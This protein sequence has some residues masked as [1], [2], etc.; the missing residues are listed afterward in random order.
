MPRGKILTDLEKGQ[1]LAFKAENLSLR[2]IARRLDR[3]LRVVQNFLKSPTDYGK[4]K[5]PGR[6]N[7]LS[8][9]DVAHITRLA[10]NSSSSV[11]KIRAQSGVTA[12][13]ST[14]WRA[15][16]RNANIVRSKMA[17]VQKLLPRHITARLKF[18]HDNMGTNWK[19]VSRIMIKSLN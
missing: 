4:I 17:I 9:R 6:K 1:I 15:L 12:S 3:S 10:S 7:K 11:A 2:E 16:N 14:V 5:R 13:K 18:A 8:E 19:Q